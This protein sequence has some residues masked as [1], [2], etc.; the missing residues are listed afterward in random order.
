[1]KQDFGGDFDNILLPWAPEQVTGKN[2]A[3][4]KVG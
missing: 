3:G 4:N 1:M 2:K